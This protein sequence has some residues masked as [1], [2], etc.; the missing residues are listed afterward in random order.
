MR[1]YTA[2]DKTTGTLCGYEKCTDSSNTQP[3]E[4]TPF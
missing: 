3:A 1:D 2:W 4:A